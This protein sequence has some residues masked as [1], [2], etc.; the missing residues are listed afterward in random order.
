MFN[1][2]INNIQKFMPGKAVS[3][4]DIEEYLGL[5]GGKKS[6]SKNIVLRSNGIKSR[7]YV[8]EKGTGKPL[9]TNAQIAAAAIR[10]LEDDS[11]SLSDIECLACGT[12][13]PDQ[14]MP[15]HASM[16]QGELGIDEIETISASGICLSGVNALKYAYYGIKSGEIKVA[17]STG[18]ETSS[19][20]LSAKN[21]EEES[22]LKLQE[23]KK[24][25]RIAFEKDFLR[26]MLSDGAGAMKLEN[27][28]NQDKIS[29]KIEFIDVFSYAGSMPVCMHSGLLID[30]NV[31]PRTWRSFSQKEIMEKSL[32]SVSQDVKLL[33]ENIIEY[34]VTKPLKEIIK[35]RDLKEKD[36]QYFLPHYSSEFF[37]DKVYQG[38]KKANFEIPYEKWFT[39]LTKMGNTGSASIYIMLEELFNGDALKKGDKILCYIPESGRFSSAFMSLEVV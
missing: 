15:G 24:D 34:T 38:L 25:Q 2:Y 9:F 39:N 35:K 13:S 31:D 12:T 29:L 37:R 19:V 23:L 3:N 27:R 18:S 8:L 33:N 32:L 6:K 14:L 16:V 20:I 11:F 28:P 5:I 4:Q 7:F 22:N 10:K 26:W 17:V 36:Y 1:V 30:E 21:F